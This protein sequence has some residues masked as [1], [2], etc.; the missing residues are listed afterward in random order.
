MSRYIS[1]L[2]RSERDS[3]LRRVGAKLKWLTVQN[4][5]ISGTGRPSAWKPLSKRYAKRV[6]RETATLEASGELMR[7]LRV[8]QPNGESITVYSDDPK[9]GY[10]QF[11]EGHN[12]LRPFF[13]ITTD[14]Q[15]TVRARNILENEAALE[16]QRLMR[17]QIR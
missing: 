1:F 11:G 9:A 3:I 12:P 8:G 2:T 10:H 5:G 4:F 7:S 13:P 17:G 6:G 14:G 16:V 15:L